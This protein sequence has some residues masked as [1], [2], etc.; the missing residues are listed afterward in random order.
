MKSTST[1][2]RFKADFHRSIKA[3]ADASG[4]SLTAWVI[5][6]CLDRAQAREGVFERPL[7]RRPD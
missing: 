3:A 5:G 6:A 4:M 7:Q 2:F 1:N